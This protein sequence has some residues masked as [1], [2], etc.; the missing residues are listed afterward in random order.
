MSEAMQKAVDNLNAASHP[1][2]RLP[3]MDVDAL[4]V[5]DLAEQ[6][7]RK[8]IATCLRDAPQLEICR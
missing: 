4:T 6:Q 3:I 2:A 8:D 5:A 7:G 1:K